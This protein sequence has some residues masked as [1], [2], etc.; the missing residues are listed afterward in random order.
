[1]S[2]DICRA[3]AELTAQLGALEPTDTAGMLDHARGLDEIADA[4]MRLYG[5]VAV[6]VAPPRYI[7]PKKRSKFTMASIAMISDLGM[8]LVKRMRAEARLLRCLAEVTA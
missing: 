5:R 4:C 6:A 7:D 8:P 2:A 3:W 1:M